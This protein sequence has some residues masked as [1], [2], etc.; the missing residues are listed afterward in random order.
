MQ[1]SEFFTNLASLSVKR[2]AK[3]ERYVKFF[4][5]VCMPKQILRVPFHHIH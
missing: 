4:C 2:A 1:K 5:Y 3:D